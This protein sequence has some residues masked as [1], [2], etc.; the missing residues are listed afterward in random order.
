MPILLKRRVLGIVR[1]L[2]AS[3]KARL[4]ECIEK[5][6]HKTVLNYSRELNFWRPK[7]PMER[8]LLSAFDRELDRLG[9]GIHK[10][11]ILGS[12]KKR[13]V[14]QTTPHLGATQGPRF[15]CI[16]W[17][18]SLGV[19]KGDFYVVAMY[20]GIP[21]SNHT[22]PGRINRH[23]G[24]INLFPSAMQDA[25]VYRSTIPKKLN[26]EI[27]KLPHSFTKFLPRAIEGESYTKW[28]L[29]S[30]QH[31]ERKIL[32]KN[33]LVYL[34]INEVVTNY[35]TSV[36]KNRFHIMHKVFFNPS[37]RSAFAEAFSGEIMFYAPV[38]KGKYEEMENFFLTG[39]ALKSRSRT[40][41][42]DNAKILIREL[43]DGRLCPAL[44]PG[45]LVLAFLNQFKCF[46]SFAQVEYLPVYQE[47]F[48]KLPIFKEFKFGS[49]PTAN[50]TTG[51]LPDGKNLFPADI[52]IEGKE[53]NPNPKIL[54]GELLVGMKENLL[55]SYFT[56]T[57][58]STR[59]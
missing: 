56:G 25:L 37:V 48:A 7:R 17:L 8:E 50:L 54:F 18:A 19:P 44:L 31:I 49:V 41:A 57:Q 28:A 53:F 55:G 12:L 5:N 21:F 36:L 33:N 20:S 47:K 30:C 22:R 34:D 4:A 6:W 35:L 40:I 38:Q 29:A 51:T 11:E 23:S 16:N 13:R 14:I 9:M 15:F 52:I 24:G 10:A 27:E 42:L 3:G 32:N 58:K 59:K 39:D 43:E 26:E 46:G 2:K 1:A 45:F